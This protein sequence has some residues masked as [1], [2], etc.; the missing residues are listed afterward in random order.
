MYDLFLL[1]FNGSTR[2]TIIGYGYKEYSY[3]YNLRAGTDS[4]VGTLITIV[5]F[6]STILSSQGYLAQNMAAYTS[7]C[8]SDADASGL[9]QSNIISQDD[10]NFVINARKLQKEKLKNSMDAIINKE[11]NGFAPPP[12]K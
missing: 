12:L 5:R 10:F 2:Y 8:I 6:A 1:V 9:F 7:N 3:R 4:V 11:F